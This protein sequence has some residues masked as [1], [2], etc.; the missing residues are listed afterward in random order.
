MAL[1]ACPDCG[2]PTSSWRFKCQQ[3]G[4]RITYGGL[5]RQDSH[6]LADKIASSTTNPNYVAWSRNVITD[7]VNGG[8]VAGWLLIMATI[9]VATVAL[10]MVR[11]LVRHYLAPNPGDPEPAGVF[12]YIAVIPPIAVVFFRLVAPIFYRLHRRLRSRR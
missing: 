8:G 1:I 3:C 6:R 12:L 5:R 9:A 10:L 4:H 11:A 7:V 2:K